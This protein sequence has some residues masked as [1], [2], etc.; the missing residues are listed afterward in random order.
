MTK[1]KFKISLSHTNIHLDINNKIDVA[2]IDHILSLLIENR[3][4]KSKLIEIIKN[5]SFKYLERLAE[6]GLLKD[7]DGPEVVPIYEPVVTNKAV[8]FKRDGGYSALFKQPKKSKKQI[9][10]K[11]IILP[12]VIGII[13][14]LITQF[15]LL[16]LFTK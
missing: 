14:W 13:L 4:D 6:D 11:E 8:N 3:N 10:V 9:I 7:I 2:N 16:P 1:N 12:I 5:I 15:V